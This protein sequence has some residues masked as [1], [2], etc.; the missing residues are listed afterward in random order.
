MPVSFSLTPKS[1]LVVIHNLTG[2]HQSVYLHTHLMKI[3]PIVLMRGEINVFCVDYL[4]RLMN[5]NR[6]GTVFCKDKKTLFSISLADLETNSDLFKLKIPDKNI[7][8]N[9]V[10]K[11]NKA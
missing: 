7:F 10:F 3:Q 2:I 9:R 11:N 6:E 4:I 5:N 1:E 8:C